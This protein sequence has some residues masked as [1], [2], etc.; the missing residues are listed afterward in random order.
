VVEITKGVD[1]FNPNLETSLHVGLD[2]CKRR[3]D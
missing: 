3:A 1:V 2:E